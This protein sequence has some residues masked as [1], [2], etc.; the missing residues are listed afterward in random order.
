M[1]ELLN[2]LG[3]VLVLGGVWSAVRSL[4]EAGRGPAAGR[5]LFGL[6]FISLGWW[7]SQL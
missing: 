2:L 4:R 3:Y 5:L 1:I 6:M 7:L